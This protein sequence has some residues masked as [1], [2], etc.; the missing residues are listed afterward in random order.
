[1]KIKEQYAK[2]RAR[3]KVL[4]DLEG[5][6]VNQ[7]ISHNSMIDIAYKPV[8]NRNIESGMMLARKG[9]MPR[10]FEAHQQNVGTHQPPVMYFQDI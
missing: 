1:M 4:E 3:V 6:S 2:S 9:I 10:K 8:D 5:D 7:A